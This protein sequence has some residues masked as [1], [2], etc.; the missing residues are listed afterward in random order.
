MLYVLRLKLVAPPAAFRATA[1]ELAHARATA[2][3]YERCSYTWTWTGRRAACGT[4]TGVLQKVL[5]KLQKVASAHDVCRPGR[6]ESS[7]KPG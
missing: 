6:A 1:L 2:R 4:L 3:G 7:V 5:Q